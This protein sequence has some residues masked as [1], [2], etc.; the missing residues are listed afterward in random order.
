[1]SVQVS[2]STFL[3]LES[4]H[5]FV[6]GAAGGVG[7][8]VVKEFLA[9]GCRVTSFDR[10]PLDI[11][12][13]SISEEQKS[14]LH[15]VSGDLRTESSIAQAFEEASS[16]LGPVQILIAN[17]GITD[18]TIH[19][20]I[21]DI[22]TERWDAVYSVNVRGTFLTIKHFLR[23]VKQAQE[24]S[25]KEL[26]NVAIVVTGS[27]T[28]VFGQA[29][30]A[31]Y[32]SGKAG[33]QYGLV[34]TVKNEIVKLNSKGRINAVA[35]GW[36]NTSLIGDRLDDPKERWAEAEATVSLRKI[37]EPS[38]AA[39]CMAFLASH[40]AAGHITGQCISVDG[41]QEGRLLWR[42]TQDEL[43]V[44]TASDSLTHRVALPTAAN[45]PEKRRRLRI[46]L[47][48]DFD[49]VS[50]LIGTGHVPENKLAD[51]S[52]AHFGGNVGVERLLRVFS[53]HGISATCVLTQAIVASGAEIGLHG[54]SHESAYS[55]SEQQER[56]ILVKCIELAT[57]LCQGKK[58]VGYRAPLYEIRESTV[59]LLEEHGF[60]YDASLNS[61]DSLPYFLPKTFAEGNPAI[62]DY[63]QPAST[64]MKPIAF[65]EQPQPGS[66]E[67]ETSLVEIPGSWYTEDATPLC[68]YPHS[69]TTQ[70]YVNTD[71]IEK[72]WLDRFEWLW[73]NESF[74][75]EGPGAGYG[76][77]FPLI[78]HPECA[79]RSHVIGMIDRFVAKL[80]AKANHASKGEITFECMT[81]VA[82][83]R[84]RRT[85]SS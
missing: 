10:N 66:Q 32:A 54:Y 17:A 73:E 45:P 52:A 51:Y 76:S 9:N 11:E 25:G 3:G 80:R 23:S 48:V 34:K 72:M 6:T 70:G 37:A 59:R 20:S 71:V 56:D 26:D 79:G 75:D 64:W 83:A 27:E 78:L 16:K 82:N 21:W 42:E 7:G 41:G 47:S 14:R 5:V 35:P 43:Q 61:H 18:E 15:H 84:K 60:L 39:R 57:S 40:R 31:E 46:C 58:P 67:A 53:R 55:L 4:C 62:P 81:D 12:A 74:V 36:I 44:K 38:D 22:D 2:S 49:A 13:L 24:V 33:L 65:T 19:P 69:A 1:M 30:H 85:P 50:G 29:G 8:A 68:F 28:G 77:I 63:N